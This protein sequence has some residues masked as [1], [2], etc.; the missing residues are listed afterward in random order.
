MPNHTLELEEWRPRRHW[1]EGPLVQG[2]M[3]EVPR[4][5]ETILDEMRR[6]IVTLASAAPLLLPLSGGRDSRMILAAARPVAY[7]SEYVTFR[8]A[9]YRRL[10]ALV[11]RHVAKVL[12][13]TRHELGL[14]SPTAEERA[15][16][17]EAIGHDASAG[18][19]RDFFVAARELSSDYGL[20][21]GFGG[22]MGREIYAPKG[23]RTDARELL[24]HS[25]APAT[26]ANISAVEDWLGSAPA[27]TRE[28]ILHLYF[29]EVRQGGWASP[30]FYGYAP[31]AFTLVP[32]MTRRSI[33]AMFRLPVDYR[34]AQTM[35]TDL[36]R[37]GW[38][39]LL[40]IPIARR[41]GPIGVLD[42]AYLRLRHRVHNVLH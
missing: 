2:T 3:A 31:F 42:R 10:D 41:P 16:Y 37:A 18:K 22:G 24:G 34:R 27:G 28:D 26:P 40:E 12:G 19:A 1:P 23:A 17:L 35:V 20:L 21:T 6:L 33:E 8:Y 7:E 29:L 11:A 5:I 13:L 9:D 15:Q 38:P 14:R 4:E 39:E 32:F 36:I 30:Q 25:L